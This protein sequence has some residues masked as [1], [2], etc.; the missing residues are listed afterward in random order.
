MVEVDTTAIEVLIS[1]SP[2]SWSTTG[3]GSATAIPV[4]WFAGIVVLQLLVLRWVGPTA[5]RPVGPAAGGGY[6][7]LIMLGC[8]LFHGLVPEFL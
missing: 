2:C 1:L 4:V 5:Q 7:L 3:T 8:C 6:Q